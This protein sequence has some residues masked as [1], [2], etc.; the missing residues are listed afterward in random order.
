MCEQD[1]SKSNEPISLK[2]DVVIE[3]T[4]W[5]NLL[6]FSGGEVP[7]MDSGSLFHCRIGDF[8]TFSRISYESLIFTTLGKMTDVN[9][10]IKPQI[11]QIRI[12][13]TYESGLIWIR[14][15]DHFWLSWRRFALSA[16]SLVCDE[17]CIY[18]YIIYSEER[19][20]VNYRAHF[21]LKVLTI[22]QTL[23]TSL[24]L[25][26]LMKGNSQKPTAWAVIVFCSVSFSS[27]FI[28]ALLHS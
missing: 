26:I 20:V 25:L 11:F 24:L 22:F 27:L 28:T 10:V 19:M 8:F 3:P 6:T 12:Q 7:D 21:C 23:M 5:K 9:K 1:Y 13:Q 2:L 4:N 18:I 14:I 16:R 17:L 15:L